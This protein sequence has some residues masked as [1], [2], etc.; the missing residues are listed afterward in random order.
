MSAPDP[1]RR[2]AARAAFRAGRATC[3]V[4]PAAPDPLIRVDAPPAA[5]IER[6]LAAG[7]GVGSTDRRRDPSADPRC[8]R[9]LEQALPP[10][11]VL[12]NVAKLVRVASPDEVGFLTSSNLATDGR[13]CAGPGAGRGQAPL[14]PKW[15]ESQRWLMTQAQSWRTSINVVA[16]HD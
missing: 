2:R 13:F 3:R 6:H 4:C 12:S 8:L 15:G 9:A 1:R 11:T 5:M 10:A 14:P 7:H 16:M